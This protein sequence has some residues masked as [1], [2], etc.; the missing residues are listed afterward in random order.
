M[1][2]ALVSTCSP[3]RAQE[4]ERLSSG[5]TAAQVP[6]LWVCKA[7]IS[8]VPSPRPLCPVCGGTQF[9][10]KGWGSSWWGWRLP[11]PQSPLLS[12]KA[13]P[14]MGAAAPGQ[15]FNMPPTCQGLPSFP[16]FRKLLHSA[17]N[18]TPGE[19]T[20]VCNIYLWG[21]LKTSPKLA[22]LAAV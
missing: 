20:R 10:G 18:L 9:C 11:H 17:S 2:G 21:I 19:T 12:V 1:I 13:E 14:Q 3:G 8:P 5:H 7:R 15:V 6:R 4:A 16:G 22:S